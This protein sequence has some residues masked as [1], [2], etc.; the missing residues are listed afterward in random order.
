ME[1]DYIYNDKK[2]NKKAVECYT[3][4]GEFVAVF[5]TLSIAA[6]AMQCS[7]SSI[8]GCCKK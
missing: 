1:N 2:D 8:S 6:D 4:S 5:P 3:L 7:I